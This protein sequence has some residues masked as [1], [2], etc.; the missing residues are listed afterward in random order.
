MKRNKIIW[1]LVGLAILLLIIILTYHYLNSHIFVSHKDEKEKLIESIRNIKEDH[2]RRN[3][4]NHFMN[5]NIL[6]QEE[7]NALY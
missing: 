3:S 2:A 6:T 7:A 1:I 4:I 5:S